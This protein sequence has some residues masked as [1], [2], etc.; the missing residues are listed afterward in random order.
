[1]NG[2]GASIRPEGDR[3]YRRSALGASIGGRE[4]LNRSPTINAACAGFPLPALVSPKTGMGEFLS[5]EQFR[6]LGSSVSAAGDPMIR[7]GAVAMPRR[8]LADP[9]GLR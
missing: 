7:P 9:M 6:A 3:L 1:M 2:E 5:H 4:G 8:E